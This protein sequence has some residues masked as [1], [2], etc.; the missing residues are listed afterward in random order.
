M[1]EI[2]YQPGY[3]IYIG[4]AKDI[5]FEHEIRINH[6]KPTEYYAIKVR[7]DRSEI[8]EKIVPIK[9]GLK[10]TSY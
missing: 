4:M 10:I 6:L 8:V 1:N 2:I 5:L 7:E 9:G 3:N